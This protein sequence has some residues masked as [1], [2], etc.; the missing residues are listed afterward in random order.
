MPI[1]FDDPPAPAP[2]ETP[3]PTPTPAATPTPAPSGET[4]PP[5]GDTP[6]PA[7]PPAGTGIAGLM[8]QLDRASAPPKPAA[9]PGDAPPA[10]K[11]GDKPPVTPPAATPP[12]T[13]PKDE[14]PDWTKAPPK[15]HKIYEGHKQKTAQQIQS[16]ESKI[17]QLETKPFEQAG[18]AAKL[19][20]MEQQLEQLKGE[21]TTAKQEL[22]RLDFRRSDEY[23]QRF[24]AKAASIYERAIPVI[25][26]IQAVDA[27][28]GEPLKT[29]DK[30]HFD[31]VRRAPE[32]EQQ[33]LA[34]KFFGNK[35]GL[36][37]RYVNAI[38]DVQAEADIATE[39]H[40][41]QH[42]VKALERDST[43]K[44]ERELYDQNFKAATDALKANPKYGKWFSENPDDPEATELLRQGFEEI[45]KVTAQLDKLPADQAA[46]YSAVF[47]ARA[48]AMPRM[49]LENNRLIAERDA[50]I[51]ELEKYRGADPGAAGRTGVQP[52]SAGGPKGIAEAAAVFDQA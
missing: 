17:K 35:A 49:V 16:L 9:K 44:K 40:A 27:E 52:P 8:D 21:S 19:K 33:E 43:T 26:Q 7:E 3:T 48:A 42:E 1:S 23:K 13:P 18:D 46:A 10:A 5:A 11:P 29:T 15:W 39:E 28:T 6:P 50:L 4:P 20:A 38:N 47:R 37:M 31:K 25:E 36:V 12:A 41:K 22:A 51:E 34:E 30:A 2:V 24:V 32:A 45:E 14:E